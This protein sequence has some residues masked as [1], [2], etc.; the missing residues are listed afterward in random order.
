MLNSMMSKVPAFLLGALLVVVLYVP[1]TAR[2]G[3]DEAFDNLLAATAN[4]SYQEPGR[5]RSQARNSFVVGGMDIRFPSKQSPTLY[6]VTPM[7]LNAG[8]GGISVH[9]GGFS[10]ISGEEIK[11]LIQSVAQNSVGVAVEMVMTTLCGQCAHV[12]QVMRSLAKDAARTAIDSCQM[13]RSLMERGRMKLFGSDE[14]RADKDQ[15]ICAGEAIH[16][17]EDMDWISSVG[18]G[19]CN[20]VEKVIS[21]IES[22]VKRDLAARGIASDS[23]GAQAFR[24]GE[25]G[26]CNTTWMLLNQ[27]ELAENNDDNNRAKVLLM[28]IIGTNIKCGTDEACAAALAAGSAGGAVRGDQVVTFPP[29][30]ANVRGSEESALNMQD[31]FLLY[32]CGTNWQNAGNTNAARQVIEQFCAVPAERQGEIA[33]IARRQIW[34]CVDYQECLELRLVDSGASALKGNGYLPKVVNLLQKGIDQVR[35]D[36]RLD[37]DVVRLIQASPVP[38]YQVINA[39]AVYPDAGAELLAVMSTYVAQLMVYADLRELIRQA[40]RMGNG[41]RLSAEDLDRIYSFLGGM[42]ATTERA[43][44]QLGQAFTMQQALMEQIRQINLAMQKEV[45]TEDMLGAT[46]LGTAINAAAQQA[47]GA[48]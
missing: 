29:R 40:E 35:T 4:V 44:L 9:F 12:M 37:A 1:A 32:M 5:Y 41:V 33:D 25:G 20:S 16:K 2:A 30:L 27:T 31:V 22:F 18:N 28:N 13:T 21:S 38:L 8:C 3:I 14:T 42:R 24:C 39:A 15:A 6:S 43:Q 48:N 26:R 17:G 19:L 23:P 11:Q 46:R 36:T 45:L 10:F 47:A 34:D 7:T